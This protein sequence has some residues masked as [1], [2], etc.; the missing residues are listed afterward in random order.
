MI[1]NKPMSFVVQHPDNKFNMSITLLDNISHVQAKYDEEKKEG[2]CI[3]R[4]KNGDSIVGNEESLKM[5]MDIMN[6]S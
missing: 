2:R 6:L 3:F 1:K 5:Y 4:M